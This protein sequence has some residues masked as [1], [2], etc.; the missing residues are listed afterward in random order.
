SS[1]RLKPPL[2][3]KNGRRRGL[4]A[5]AAENITYTNPV[6]ENKQT[7]DTAQ[8]YL[9]PTKFQQKRHQNIKNGTRHAV[10]RTD[11]HRA[12]LAGNAERVKELLKK[13]RRPKYSK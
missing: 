1:T 7:F 9:K 8:R 2:N 11:L 6:L 13:R 5:F 3:K 12:A 4:R 10:D